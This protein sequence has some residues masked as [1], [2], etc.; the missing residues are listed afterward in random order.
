MLITC[1]FISVKDV[2]ITLY[3]R[4]FNPPPTPSPGPAGFVINK[5]LVYCYYPLFLL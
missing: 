5:S 3:Y 2:E 1:C 4:Y